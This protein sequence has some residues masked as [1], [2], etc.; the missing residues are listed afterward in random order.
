MMPDPIK[1]RFMQVYRL[2]QRTLEEGGVLSVKPVPHSHTP[3]QQSIVHTSPHRKSLTSPWPQALS[4]RKEDPPKMPPPHHGETQHRI[5]LGHPR[6]PR[7]EPRRRHGQACHPGRSINLPR[8]RHRQAKML[9]RHVQLPT[10]TSPIRQLD[11]S[12]PPC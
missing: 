9:T 11:L 2:P 10:S 5:C 8:P 1:P 6:R 3:Q 7:L 12:P 4:L